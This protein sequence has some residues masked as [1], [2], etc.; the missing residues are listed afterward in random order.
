[1]G[2][3]V[4]G[5]RPRIKGAVVRMRT[6]T[7]WLYKFYL[8]P[9]TKSREDLSMGMILVMGTETLAGALGDLIKGEQPR[10]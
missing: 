2:T 5:N 4:L 8:A 9:D 3:T 6:N 7:Y 10:W 1:M